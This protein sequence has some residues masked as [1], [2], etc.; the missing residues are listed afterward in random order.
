M[1]PLDTIRAHALDTLRR[2]TPEAHYWLREYAPAA[3]A[4]LAGMLLREPSR[5]GLSVLERAAAE[6]LQAHAR[7][8][9]MFRQVHERAFPAR[10]VG[11]N[12]PPQGLTPDDERQLWAVGEV[13]RQRAHDFA[14]ML[15]DTDLVSA[16]ATPAPAPGAPPGAPPEPLD[17]QALL[18]RFKARGGRFKTLAGRVKLEPHGL[19]QEL[20][21]ETGVAR[22]TLRDRL[23]RA[24]K[25]QAPSPFPVAAVR[26][27]RT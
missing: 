25:A 27:R 10:D 14:R 8:E 16:F 6:V 17:D 15:G 5:F 20:H 13:L 3:D 19:V 9:L 24:H 23:L 7:H 1:T 21:K 12:T 2:V 11:D 22:T 4:E 18:A 26:R